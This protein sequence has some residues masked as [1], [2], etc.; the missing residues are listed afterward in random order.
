[1]LKIKWLALNNFVLR[2]D[3]V[4]SLTFSHSMTHALAA[5]PKCRVSA[6]ERNDRI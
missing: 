1:M 6:I 2:R 3:A 5:G 4:S